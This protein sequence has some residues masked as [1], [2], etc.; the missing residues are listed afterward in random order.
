[1][2]GSCK[3]IAVKEKD[4]GGGV[5]YRERIERIRVRTEKI[6]MQMCKCF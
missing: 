4:G 3:K 1:M 2:L 5:S 6:R